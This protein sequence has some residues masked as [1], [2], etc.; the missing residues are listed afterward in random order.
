MHKLEPTLFRLLYQRFLY[1]LVTKIMPVFGI[2]MA[3]YRK[4]HKSLNGHAQSQV[5]KFQS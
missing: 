4:V 5:Y 2:Q 1:K 3:F